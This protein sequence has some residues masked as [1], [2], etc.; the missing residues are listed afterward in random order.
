M[1]QFAVSNGN[2]YLKRI[3]GAYQ[4]KRSWGPLANAT[5]WQTKGA[6]KN[7]AHRAAKRGMT[8]FIVPVSLIACWEDKEQMVARKPR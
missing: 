5:L 1:T 7:A 3:H 4:T 6:A 2:E 8:V